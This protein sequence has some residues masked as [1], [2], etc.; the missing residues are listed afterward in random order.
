MKGQLVGIWYAESHSGEVFKG[1]EKQSLESRGKAVLAA[2][3]L[4]ELYTSVLWKVELTINETGYL[5]EE[6]INSSVKGHTT[7]TNWI[8]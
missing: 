7:M 1:N 2:K 3:N 5:A 6:I 4:A 8:L